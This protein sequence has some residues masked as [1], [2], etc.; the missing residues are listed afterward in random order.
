MIITE[1][2]LCKYRL[3]NYPEYIFF[4]DRCFNSKT[5]RE[6]KQVYNNRCIGYNIRGKF[7]SLKRLKDELELI[8]KK[9]YTPF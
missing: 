2:L 7:I 3:R 5:G 9:I 6:I 8:P 1:K 4:K